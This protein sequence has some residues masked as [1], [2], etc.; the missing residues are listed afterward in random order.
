[1]G[2]GRRLPTGRRRGRVAGLKRVQDDVSVRHRFAFEPSGSELPLFHGGDRRHVE[3]IADHTPVEAEFVGVA[4][5]SN[6]KDG[7]NSEPMTRTVFW[8]WL[9]STAVSAVPLSWVWRTPPPSL[10]GAI[11]LIGVL[12]GVGQI[13]L[14]RAYA[15]A[16][17]GRIGPFSYTT[18]LFAAV[19]GWLLWGEVLD[20]VS[21]GGVALV[22]AA[23]VP[24]TSPMYTHA[25]FSV[26]LSL[27][28]LW[29]CF[30]GVFLGTLIGVLPGIGPLATIAMLL[31]L[32][33]NVPP[34][35]K[36]AMVSIVVLP[37]RFTPRLG[38]M[39]CTR[40]CA[41]AARPPSLS[42]PPS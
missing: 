24:E 15:L 17:A 33:F 36:F 5:V 16:P 28:N 31:P 38:A 39:V 32:T 13:L 2:R 8:F 21:F 41:R 20:A 19:F 9:L 3:G 26:A 10:W 29:F 34:A 23:A 1:M 27:Q 4:R 42:A 11:L 6:L 12:A 25:R 40:L 7:G 37:P 18:V 35:V 22:T 30:I 14:T